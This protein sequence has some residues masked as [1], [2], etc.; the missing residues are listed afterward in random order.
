MPFVAA[1]GTYVIEVSRNYTSLEGENCRISM[2]YVWV[3][4]SMYCIREENVCYT[5]CDWEVPS[6]SSSVNV[7]GPT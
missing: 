7:L 5:T 4:N 6:T 3:V 1:P 2:N